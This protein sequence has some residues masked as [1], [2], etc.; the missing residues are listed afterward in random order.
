MSPLESSNSHR[1][2]FGFQQIIV[3]ATKNGK[4]FG[5]DSSNGNTLWTRN[6]GLFGEQGSDLFL[7]DMWLVREV[8][9]GVNPTLAVLAVRT[10]MQPSSTVAFH[11]DG[12]TG[13]VKGDT[14]A[15][16]G[17]PDGKTLFDGEHVTAFLTP[18]ENCGTRNK[19]LAV[20][21]PRDEVSSAIE[22][23]STVIE[24]D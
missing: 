14:S 22:V 11:F 24:R 9:D 20:V 6:L 10:G 5:L 21:S 15:E 13:E 8:G 17:L 18:F 1:D 16:I 12:F 23:R 2:Q 4:I 7:K 19:V 3:A